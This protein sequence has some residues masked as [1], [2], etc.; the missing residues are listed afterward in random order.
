MTPLGKK[1]DIYVYL[2]IHTEK[3]FGTI[4]KNCYL[5]RVGMDRDEFLLMPGFFTSI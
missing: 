2:Y 5:W 3:T 1:S 4:Q